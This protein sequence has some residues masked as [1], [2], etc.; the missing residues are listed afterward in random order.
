MDVVLT[1][2]EVVQPHVAFRVR[3]AD[4]S[5]GLRGDDLDQGSVQTESGDGLDELAL[6]VGE[7]GEQGVAEQVDCGA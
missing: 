1:D 4:G 3:A 6:L 7:V 5:R 2:A